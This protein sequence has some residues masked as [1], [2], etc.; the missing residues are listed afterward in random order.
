MAAHVH[1]PSFTFVFLCCLYQHLDV[2]FYSCWQC[3][4]MYRRKLQYANLKR[5]FLFYINRRQLLAVELLQQ[6]RIH[7]RSGTGIHCCT[8]GRQRLLSHSPGGSTFLCKKMTSRRYFE[9][10]MSSRNAKVSRCVFECSC[11]ISSKS[12]LK[13]WSLRLFFK[14]VSQQEEEQ[15]V[16]ISD[17]FLI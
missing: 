2:V 6:V 1:Y 7:Y 14:V 11:Q 10:M 16:A 3:I 13:Q 9:T 4:Y 17:Q 12:D 8:A 15:D 5:C